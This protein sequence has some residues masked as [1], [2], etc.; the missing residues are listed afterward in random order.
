TCNLLFVIKVQKLFD[1]TKPRLV[2]V[3]ALFYVF[4]Y[5]TKQRGCANFD[6]APCY[7]LCNKLFLGDGEKYQAERKNYLLATKKYQ[8]EN[9]PAKPYQNLFRFSYKKSRGCVP[10]RTQPR[11]CFL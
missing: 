6:T 4:Q 10:M 3:R 8:V 1:M 9:R 5:I 11:S 2:K 7:K